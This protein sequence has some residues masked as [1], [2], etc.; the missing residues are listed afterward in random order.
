MPGSVSSVF[1]GIRTLTAGTAA[2]QL[3]LILS[4]LVVARLY[5]PASVGSYA[6]LVS[7]ATILTPLAT[8]KL[9]A[10]IPTSK[11]SAEAYQIARWA[12]TSCAILVALIMAVTGLG[13]VLG[14][15]ELGA[16]GSWGGVAIGALVVCYSLYA[17]L[18]Q[19][20]LLKRRFGQL[21]ARGVMQNGSIGVSQMLAS[22]LTKG[23]AGLVIGEVLGRGVGLLA[24]W[25][26]WGLVRREAAARPRH[27]ASTSILSRH[28]AVA[29]KYLP[30]SLVD[31]ATVSLPVL[32]ATFW[33]GQMEAGYLA[34]TQRLF[35]VPVLVVATGIGQVLMAELANSLRDGRQLD[36]KALSHPIAVVSGL[37]LLGGA[38]VVLVGPW[39]FTTFFGANWTEAGVLARWLAPSLATGLL[40]GATGG[41]LVALRKWNAL[42][43]FAIAR[44]ALTTSAG[45]VAHAWGL[46]FLPVFALMYLLG[47]A[48]Q[49]AAIAYTVN[50]GVAAT[51]RPDVS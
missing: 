38:A 47:S 7:L 21:A 8:L 32:L 35:A 39:I 20:A 5:P 49:L 28:G 34:M 22:F 30:A 37:A 24:L 31:A 43:G 1:R 33:F 9:E 25:P 3:V 2:S 36:V 11:D 44:L 18:T 4:T 13:V 40:W 46:G 29:M 12:L 51:K 48:I 26:T 16:L 6:S 27:S 23:S 41:L 50:V 10:A 45:F 14:A 42:L 15:S 17:V 19:L